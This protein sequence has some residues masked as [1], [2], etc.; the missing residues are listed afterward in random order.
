VAPR[1]AEILHQH[2]AAMDQEVQQRAAEYISLSA[3]S[4]AEV[5]STVLGG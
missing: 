4:L 1:V 2:S 5:K 3:P